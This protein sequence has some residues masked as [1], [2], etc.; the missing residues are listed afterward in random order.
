M[1]NKA[2]LQIYPER[3]FK[4][5]NW[6]SLSFHDKGV[7]LQLEM[8]AHNTE[9]R[10][11]LS[12]NGNPLNTEDIMRL[13]D[14][15]DE[16]AYKDTLY[17]LIYAGFVEIDSRGTL[18]IPRLVREEEIRR[19]Y[20]LN[21]LLNAGSK[22]LLAGTDFE[23]RRREIK[24]RMARGEVVDIEEAIAY[25][26]ESKRNVESDNL[27]NGADLVNKSPTSAI[28]NA[29]ARRMLGGASARPRRRQVRKPI[30][31]D[32]LSCPLE[33][34]LQALAIDSS[35]TELEIEELWEEFRQSAREES[36]RYADWRM[37]FRYWIKKHSKS[38]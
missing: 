23:R 21:G 20:Y 18:R 22:R 1:R 3:Q 25:L 8:L 37:A 9:R 24:E 10:G 31:P 28:V 33:C 4:D 11:I 19:K 17:R 36:W 34:Q 32:W 7:L 6:R 14:M 30:P 13:L 12:L 35:L 5:E 16:G 26:V 2:A 15:E 29:L 38:V 27:I